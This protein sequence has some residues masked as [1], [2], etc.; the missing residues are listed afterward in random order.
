MD[1][2]NLVIDKSNSVMYGFLLLAV[3]LIVSI[4]FTFIF[5]GI[6]IRYALHAMRLLFSKHKKG[7][8]VSGLASFC[9][10]TASRVGTGNMAGIMVAI[11]LGGPGSIFWMWIMA[12]LGGSLAFAE[13]TLAQLYKEKN[14]N[15]QY[16]GGASYYIKSKL[17][18]P[19]IAVIFSSFMILAYTSFNGIQANTIASA[20]V[21]FNIPV[22]GTG[23][24]LTV[25]TA[26]IFLSPKN[27]TLINACVFIVPIMAIPYILIGLII[28]FMN[29]NKVP[30]VF[31]QIFI[32]AF[33]P[34][35]IFGG[36]L[37]T[38]IST[39]LKRGL[40]SNEAGMGGAPHAAAAAYSEHPCKQGFIQMF[41]VFTDTL[42]ICSISA[43]MLLLSPEAMTK[44]KELQG[45]QLLQYA[46]ETH[47]GTFGSYFVTVCILL[48]AYSSILGNFF[49]IKTGASAIKDN[50]ISYSI[51]VTMTL[52]LVFAGSLAS[53]N[54]I[55]NMGDFFMGL[56]AFLNIG[57]LLILYKP[58]LK[59]I[60]NYTAQLKNG[61]E[62][63]YHK[64][65]I[66]EIESDAITQWGDK[67]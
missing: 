25:I 35:A 60:D 57:I 14:S 63:V 7:D 4:F 28:F 41:S 38:T 67:D 61:K 45:I 55:W 43:F 48:F 50:K 32:Q 9:I 49:Y 44:I 56:M 5:K 36:A 52:I 15:G 13:S 64:K 18:K 58:S 12:L 3:F 47:L 27:N 8:G 59:L 29:I 26:I 2:I 10:S 11:S 30:Y 22:I 39:G 53:F 1:I 62:P 16:V 51:V 20:M 31:S 34:M 23:I 37:G 42:V 6:Q 54:T 46:M 24:F 40:F 65:D 17:K 21:K 19:F 66:R 33:K